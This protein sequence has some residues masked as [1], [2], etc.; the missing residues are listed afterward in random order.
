M[1]DGGDASVIVS[2]LWLAAGT[3]THQEMYKLWTVTLKCV[4][5]LAKYDQSDRV[6]RLSYHGYGTVT[7]QR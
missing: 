2:E 3:D 6:R 5:V 4:A 1:S 7:C